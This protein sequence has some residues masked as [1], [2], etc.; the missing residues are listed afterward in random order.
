MKDDAIQRAILS[1]M[2]TAELLE[3][4]EW[5][6]REAHYNPT[7]TMEVEFDLDAL[8]EELVKRLTPAE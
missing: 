5:G 3:K 2:S 1:M 6:V 4:F 8:R 7:G